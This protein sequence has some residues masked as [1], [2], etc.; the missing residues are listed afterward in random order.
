MLFSFVLLMP[1]ALLSGLA[2]PVGNM[3]Q[4]LQYATLIN[5]PRYA[6]D[7][8]HRVYLEGATLPQLV[9][10]LWP[11]ALGGAVTLTAAQWMFRNKVA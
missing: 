3:P 7:I 10:L 2:T 4:W 5:P 9:P 11:L 1:F 6:I 8:I